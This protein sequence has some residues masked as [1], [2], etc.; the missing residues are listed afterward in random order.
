MRPRIPEDVARVVETH[1]E[2]GRAARR[3]LHVSEKV[4]AWQVRQAAARAAILAR[5]LRPR[6]A[7][8]DSAT[9]RR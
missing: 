9:K 8:R 6:S 5:R 1:A 4:V 3:A 7:G 2:L